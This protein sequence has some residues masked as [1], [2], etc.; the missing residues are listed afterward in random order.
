MD[1]STDIGRIKSIKTIIRMSESMLGD[2]DDETEWKKWSRNM[3][4][5]LTARYKNQKLHSIPGSLQ[6]RMYDRMAATRS[7]IVSDINYNNQL[8]RECCS[9]LENVLLN[10]LSKIV[11]GYCMCLPYVVDAERYVES[12]TGHFQLISPEDLSGN[13]TSISF[14]VDPLF[15]DAEL[16]D[17]DCHTFRWFMSDC[18]WKSSTL[19]RDFWAAIL[20]GDMGF[21]LSALKK[22]L[23]SWHAREIE[24]G[25]PIESMWDEGYL[26]LVLRRFDE[27]RHAQREHSIVV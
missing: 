3:R 14:T 5:R 4:K 22:G 15:Y 20:I 7:E 27:F 11:M 17:I 24:Q 6:H 1:E 19:S 8:I 21:L 13:M 23:L 2:P 16:D 18:S 26:P 9:I 25:W 12:K 10:D